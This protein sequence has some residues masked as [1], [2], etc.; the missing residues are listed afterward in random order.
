MTPVPTT[1]NR[2]TSDQ[3]TSKRAGTDRGTS[4][5]EPATAPGS[6]GPGFRRVGRLAQGYDVRQVDGFFSRAR[7]AYE[8]GAQRSAVTSA[9]VRRVGFDLVRGGYEVGQVDSALDRLEDAFAR[10]EYEATRA[11][12]GED[13]VLAELTKRAQVLRGRLVR[14]D[15]QRFDRAR[16]LAPAYEV[17]DVDRLCV[18]LL[19]YFDDG[20]PMSVDEVR[21]AV[22][23]PRR[24]SRGYAEPQVDAFLDRV[25][26]VMAA[27]E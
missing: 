24:G 20:E 21:R 19:G 22:F 8:R 25:V 2:A 23:R 1:S 4:G 5:D 14:P 26:E 12:L 9:D 10:R 17:T 18:R 15:G 7:A 27:V 16:G 11:R 3:P 13:G 6:H